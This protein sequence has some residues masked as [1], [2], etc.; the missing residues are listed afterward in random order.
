MSQANSKQASSSTPE[1]TS[2]PASKERVFYLDNLRTCLTGLVIYH[3]TSVSYGGL[4]SW[5]YISRLHPP[6]T[7]IPLI[8]FNAINQSYF[9]GSFFYLSGYFSSRTLKQKG[10]ERFLRTKIL[11]LGVPTL[12]YTLV[13]PPLQILVRCWG[14]G[15]GIGAGSELVKDY[16]QNLQGVRGPVWFCATL[17]ALD[18]LLA[19]INT[20]GRLSQT[21]IPEF[22]FWPSMI[23]DISIGYLVRLKYPVGT[24]FKPLGIQPAYL[25]QYIACYA[26]GTSSINPPMTKA[27]RNTLLSCSIIST[28]LT[29]GLLYAY[30][31]NVQSL[32]SIGVLT[33][34]HRYTPFGTRQPGTWQVF[35]S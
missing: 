1:L 25:P 4:G 19:L 13:G 5:A 6:G 35:L 10:S 20:S 21:S 3:H 18:T 17:L 14:E 22:T 16:W 9:M 34:L 15:K 33:Q 23:L 26:L 32:H 30:P 24:S 12:F 27:R 28:P 11:K 31:R 7:S 29:L 2:P 8:V